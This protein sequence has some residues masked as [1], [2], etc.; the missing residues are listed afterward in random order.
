MT[1]W[2]AHEYGFVNRVFPADKLE[3]ETLAYAHRVAENYLS[4]PFEMHMIKSSIKR[5]EDAMGFATSMEESCDISCLKLGLQTRDET[6]PAE[7]GYART[8]VAME[9][10][11]LSKPWIDSIHSRG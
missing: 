9:N 3:E 5:M 1:A 4:N 7:G 8:K 11:K 2:E 6:P 10:F